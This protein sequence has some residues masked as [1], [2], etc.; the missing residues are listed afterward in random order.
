MKVL[1]YIQNKRKKKPLHFTLIDPDKQEPKQAGELAKLAES[2][3][4]DAIMVGGSWGDAFGKQLNETITEI[5]KSSKLPVILFP[6]SAQ[7]I[8]DKADALFFMSLLNSRSTQY[9]IDEQAKGAIYV[10]KFGLEPLSMAYLIFES[11]SNTA[12]GW[13]GDVKAIPRDKPEI[14]AAYSLAAKYFGMKMVYLEGGSGAKL[15][16]PAEAVGAVKHAVG[17]DV[18]VIVGGGI[19]EPE[20]AK[21]KV[22]AG[23]DI[24]V[25][26]TIAENNKEKLK[27][28]IKA[29]KG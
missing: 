12:A 8:S 6:S 23:A 24:I 16:V 11:D 28:I 15:S 9:L 18:F 22:K 17:E 20:V 5:K 26:G 7:Q 27:E 29:I 19:R 10:R 14:A 1:E 25:T 2:Y 3:G 21:E 4:S 13:V